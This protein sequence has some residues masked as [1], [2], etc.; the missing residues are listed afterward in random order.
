MAAVFISDMGACAFCGFF[1][2]AFFLE[3]EY[4]KNFVL[5][6][7]VGLFEMK[8]RAAEKISKRTGF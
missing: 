4:F 6:L 5:C 2:F 7:S 1:I 8:V 3:Y